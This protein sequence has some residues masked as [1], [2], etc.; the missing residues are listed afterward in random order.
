MVDMSKQQRRS[1]DIAEQPREPNWDSQRC[2]WWKRC[3]FDKNITMWQVIFGVVFFISAILLLV[4]LPLSFSY[5]EYDQW[6]LKK[7]KIENTVELDT[8]YDVGRYFWGV[9]HAPLTYSR[10]YQKVEK[11]FS[12]FPSSGLEFTI[13]VIFY[14]RIQKENLGKIYKS[15][16]TALHS[17]VVNR[18]NARIKN[19]APLFDLEQYIT[20]RPLITVALHSGLVDELASIWV[21]VPYN[22]FYLAEVKIPNEIKQRNLDASIQKQTNIEEKNRQLAT[23][24][25]KET[26]KLEQEIN[27]NITLIGATAVASQERIH[28]EAEAIAEKVRSSADG[29]GMKNLFMQINVTDSTTKEKYVSYFAYLDSI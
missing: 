22:K 25:R 15:F 3:G 27:A 16:G 17:Q 12:I 14:Y 18:A 11:D 4:M 1:M 5:V 23:L 9:D 20:H 2:M 13:N 24:V 19:I 28:K 7:N 8:T 6:A 26:E 10:Q 21:D 29:L